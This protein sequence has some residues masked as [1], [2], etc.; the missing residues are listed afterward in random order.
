MRER[1]YKYTFFIR[2]L[3]LSML[4][5]LSAC[6]SQNPQSE[7]AE[8]SEGKLLTNPEDV[9]VGFAIDTLREERWYRDKEALEKAVEELG[10]S[11]KTLAANGNQEVQIQQAQL[12]INEGVDVLVV[13]P[14]DSEG[15]SEIVNLAHD[16]GIKVISYDRLITG[17]D[18]D[19]Y[20]S[21][22]NVKVGELQAQEILNQ[23]EEGNFAYVGGAESDNNALLFREGAMN[24]LKPYL[25][26]GAVNLV[27]DSYTPGWDPD[28]ARDQLTT[29]LDSSNSQL[30][31]VIAANDG[32][33]GGVVE[34]IG[35]Q[36]GEIAISGQDAELDGVQ[37]IV[38]GTQTMTVYKSIDL[39]ANRAAELAMQIA[40]GEEI[41]TDSLTDNGQ[42]EVPSIL[43]DPIAVTSDNI[44]DTIIKEGHLTESEI[45]DTE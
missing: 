17:A 45:Y 2:M 32:T 12:L 31:A 42:I 23:T 36:V 30:D 20:L 13:V 33:A 43:L 25:D 27:Y 35:N 10:G 19:Y 38:E 3:S 16:A 22:D 37:R 40:A 9:Y 34:A 21:F 8:A 41:G 24:V 44:E 6:S 5:V 15:A 1:K 28:A 18:L 11:V 14:T 7:S 4:F 39:I 26:S 29:F